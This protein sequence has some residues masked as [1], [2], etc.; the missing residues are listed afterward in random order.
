MKAK[1][2]KNG[3][4]YSLKING[5]YVAFVN[6]DFIEYATQKFRDNLLGKLSLKNCQ[7]IENG[8]DLD[9]LAEKEYFD[10]CDNTKRS[11]EIYRRIFK[12]GFQKALEILG[13]KKFSEEDVR[14]AF[15]AGLSIGYGRQF[16]IENRLLEI[17]YYIQSLQQAEWGVEIVMEY[18]DKIELSYGATSIEDSDYILRTQ[19]I[20]LDADGNLILKRKI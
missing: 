4:A 7:A 13:D 2:I 12:E 8:Y 14:R 6:E 16:E 15:S 20:K 18:N 11:S 1:L 3:N 9:E 10:G 19:Y 5:E 17:D